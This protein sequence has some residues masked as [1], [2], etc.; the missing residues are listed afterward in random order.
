MIQREKALTR[1]EYKQVLMTRGG[2][3]YFKGEIIQEWCQNP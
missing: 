3:S 1:Q 2:I